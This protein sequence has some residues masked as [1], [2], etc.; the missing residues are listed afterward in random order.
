MGLSDR[1]AS[2]PLPA[3]GTPISGAC[4]VAMAQDELAVFAFDLMHTTPT[5]LAAVCLSMEDW[6]LDCRKAH[7]KLAA[8]STYMLVVTSSLIGVSSFGLWATWFMAPKGCVR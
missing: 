6:C 1:R 8:L 5:P 3:K 7:R 4:G 2:S